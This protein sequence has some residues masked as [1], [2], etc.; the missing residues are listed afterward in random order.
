MHAIYDWAPATCWPSSATGRAPTTPRPRAPDRRERP[1]RP[2]HGRPAGAGGLGLRRPVGRRLPPRPARAA[3]R[4]ARR[5]L[6]RLRR[7]SP[8]SPRPR[9]RPFVYDGR[10][11]EHR[12]RRHGA[13][14][15]GSGRTR[16]RGL[17]AE[18]RPGRQPRARRPARRR[19]ARR[20]P[21]CGRPLAL[22]SRCSSWARSTARSA[23]S[24]S[25]P[26]TSTRSSPTATRE[27]RRREFAAFAGFSGEEVP[28]PQDPET[29]AR[30]VLDPAAGDPAC[31]SSTGACSRCARELPDAAPRVRSDEAGG[32]DRR[33]AA[34]PCE[35]V[36]NFGRDDAEVPV[37]ASGVVLAT[38]AGR[39]AARRPAAAAARSAGRWCD[40]GLA[41]AAR[42]PSAPPGTATGTNFSLFSEHADAGGA[43]PVRRRRTARRAST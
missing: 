40:D 29:F 15:D 16:V 5:L 23:P 10:Y 7:A 27:G 43:L 33:C 38:D 13:P 31:A 36:G 2:A 28:D 8:T 22:T 37:E 35:V 4:R 18:P 17:L 19:D 14:A 25:S 9:A 24:S 39:G 42:S 26:T 32:V 1:Q 41:G 6:R 20:W 34:G 11:S 30:S 3:D 12:R 21:R